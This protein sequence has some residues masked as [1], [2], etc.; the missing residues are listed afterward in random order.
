MVIQVVVTLIFRLFPEII[1]FGQDNINRAL[2][3]F[4]RDTQS[5]VTQI[6]NTMGEASAHAQ[7]LSKPITT[8]DKLRNSEHRLYLLIDQN[9]NQ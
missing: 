3:F 1:T 8:A 2:L 4:F 9:A 6:V 7:G 5:K